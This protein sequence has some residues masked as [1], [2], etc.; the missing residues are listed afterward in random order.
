MNMWLHLFFW[1]QSQK[2]LQIMAWY[3]TEHI[4]ILIC[5]R[6]EACP[7]P[8]LSVINFSR[9]MPFCYYSNVKVL[10]WCFYQGVVSGQGGGCYSMNRAD[11]NLCHMVFFD[12]YPSKW[13]ECEPNL[14]FSCLIAACFSR[15][16]HHRWHWSLVTRTNVEGKQGGRIKFPQPGTRTTR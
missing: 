3:T 9:I 12:I 11:I 4:K 1:H 14:R 13:A 7:L 8:Y 15:C 6:W 5:C 2:D 16:R 10:H